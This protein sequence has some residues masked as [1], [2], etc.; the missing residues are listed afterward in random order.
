LPGTFY[1]QLCKQVSLPLSVIFNISLSTS[2]LPTQWKSAIVI[3]VY[4]SGPASLPSNYRPIS[5]TS[6][7][8]KI[9]ESIIKDNILCYL[10][11]NNLITKSQHGFL[12]KRSTTTQLL[13]C[14]R[15]WS[16]NRLNKVQTDIIYLD[17]AS[18]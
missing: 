11:K 13:E 10:I 18:A 5:L 2:E 7:A 17:Y 16:C 8:C 4:K 3:P 14:C 12:T 15:D 6:S 9:L 1:K